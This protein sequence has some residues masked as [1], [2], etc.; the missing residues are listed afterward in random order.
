MKVSDALKQSYDEQYEESMQTWREELARYKALHIQALAKP[1]NPE[2]VIEVGCG[3][4]SILKWLDE[5]AFC[6][7]LFAVDISESG[8]ERTQARNLKH[9][10]E[11][12][13]FDGY[14][15]PY[16]DD[17]FDLAYCSHVIEH[18]EFPRQLIREIQRVSVHQVYEIPIDFS[19]FVDRKL[20][21]FLSYGHINI[22]TPAL[23]KFLI[24]SEGHVVLGERFNIFDK[25]ALGLIYKNNRKAQWIGY[26]KRLVIKNVSI[27]LKV[28]PDSYTV[29]TDKKGQ[30]QIFN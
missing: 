4:G 6:P 22:Y 28:K 20:T 19:L 30:V 10:K 24:K 21:H 16:E 9:L 11:V 7:A 17:A 5:W 27:F 26:L 13:Q 18:V 3:E 1:L 25:K 2:K 23:F 8:V 14:R 29:L 15:L 12:K